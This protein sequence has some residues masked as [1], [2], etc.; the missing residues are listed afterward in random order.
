MKNFI[1]SILFISVIALSSCS[2]VGS[3]GDSSDSLEMIQTDRDLYTA[4]QL[5]TPVSGPF[6][7]QYEFEMI[8]TF[9]NK[10][11]DTIYVNSCFGHIYLQAGPVLASPL[12]DDDESSYYINCS[13]AGSLTTIALEPGV[14]RIDTLLVR[15]PMEWDRFNKPLGV[16]EGT[17]Q[18]IMHRTGT[19][20]DDENSIAS[21]CEFSRDEMPRS[22]TFEI[23]LEEGAIR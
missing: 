17:F 15:S 2:L 3:N 19:C 6:L 9:E 12:S 8:A 7:R 4:E 1:E 11:D 23:K 14:V 10:S 13:S 21:E 22:N 5:E 20:L 18:L 16:A